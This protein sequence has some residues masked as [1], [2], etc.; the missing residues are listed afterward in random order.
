[1]ILSEVTQSLT[2]HITLN[3]PQNAAILSLRADRS[4]SL[5]ISANKSV[6]N[7]TVTV[8]SRVKDPDSQVG[9]QTDRCINKKAL[10]FL[11]RVMDAGVIGR[12]LALTV[13]GTDTQTDRE[14]AIFHPFLSSDFGFLL[15]L[16]YF[17]FQA[18]SPLVA[19][20]ILISVSSSLSLHLFSSVLS[21]DVQCCSAI[22]SACSLAVT[23]LSLLSQ[24]TEN[25]HTH[26]WS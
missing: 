12:D 19:S 26:L 6:L 2:D 8:D 22:C 5:L 18:F 1:M 16:S 13:P 14:T 3:Q 23:H 11:Q 7:W 9:R 25:T 15:P 20:F 4:I 10:K 21:R 24:S 17:F